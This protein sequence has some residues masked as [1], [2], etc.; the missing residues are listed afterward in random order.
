M[1]Y[2]KSMYVLSD[3]VTAISESISMHSFLVLN[4]RLGSLI[5]DSN[6]QEP[7]RENS[8]TSTELDQMQKTS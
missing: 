2:D 1:L 3:I 4:T 5:K 6:C 7:S 8:K